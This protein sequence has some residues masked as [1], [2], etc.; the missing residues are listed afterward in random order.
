MHCSPPACGIET[1]PAPPDGRENE[2]LHNSNIY[3]NV[4]ASYYGLRLTNMNLI[5]IYNSFNVYRNLC[6]TISKVARS[7]I[8]VLYSSVHHVLNVNVSDVTYRA[9]AW[10]GADDSGRAGSESPRDAGTRGTARDSVD[11]KVVDHDIQYYFLIL[12]SMIII[13]HIIS[14]HIIHYHNFY[15]VVVGNVVV[16]VFS[17]IEK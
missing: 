5:T 1:R 3:V 13:T 11:E 17:I 4:N 9:D 6:C 8:P 12:H 14:I 10:G 16:V 15:Y 7:M 2:R